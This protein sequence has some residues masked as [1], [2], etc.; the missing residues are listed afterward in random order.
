[1]AD[2]KTLKEAQQAAQ[3]V[4]ARQPS[5]LVGDPG[6]AVAMSCVDSVL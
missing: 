2:L 4:V 6:M 3:P 1:M 5:L